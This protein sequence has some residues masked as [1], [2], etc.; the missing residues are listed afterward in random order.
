MGKRRGQGVEGTG[1]VANLPLLAAIYLCCD[2]LGFSFT[3]VQIISLQGQCA[4]S[5]RN[6][7]WKVSPFMDTVR[8]VVI[9]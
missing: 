8:V 1:W 7:L 6:A 4:P 5:E 3:D 2:N 9:P